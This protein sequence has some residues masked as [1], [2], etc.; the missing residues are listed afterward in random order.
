MK[1]TDGWMHGFQ[2]LHYSHVTIRLNMTMDNLSVT[3]PYQNLS[4]CYRYTIQ[5]S[6]KGDLTV[7]S[8][9]DD[10]SFVACTTPRTAMS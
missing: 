2:Q 7:I 3:C 8:L 10:D 9:I 6:Q 1:S 4:S 5:A